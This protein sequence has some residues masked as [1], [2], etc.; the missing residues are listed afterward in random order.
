MQPQEDMSTTE[1]VG[2]T[3]RKPRKTVQDMLKSVGDSLNDFGS[4]NDEQDGQDE[5]DDKQDTERS[6]LSDDDEPGWMMSTI[7][8]TVQHRIESFRQK[9]MRLHELKQSGWWV[10]ANYFCGRD[11]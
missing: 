6:K 9:Q 5:E 1:N 3:T 8:K 4:S 7:S 10:A 2:A 11:M